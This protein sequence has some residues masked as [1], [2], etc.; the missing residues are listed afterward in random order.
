MNNKPK[1]FNCVE[2]KRQAQE[3]LEKEFEA[4]R[5]EFASFSDFLN[6]KVMESEETLEIW[7]RFSKPGT[8]LLTPLSNTGDTSQPCTN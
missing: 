4:R 8:P 2:A 5:G 1:D 7:R 3:A 6:A